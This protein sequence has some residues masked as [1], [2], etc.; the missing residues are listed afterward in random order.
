[1]HVAPTSRSKVGTKVSLS[2]CPPLLSPAPKV[3]LNCVELWQC[4]KGLW[5]HG[6]VKNPCQ[7]Y[8][9]GYT[10][11]PW[12]DINALVCYVNC[13]WVWVDMSRKWKVSCG[14]IMVHG[15]VKSSCRSWSDIVRDDDPHPNCALLLHKTQVGN[16][17]TQLVE[18]SNGSQCWISFRNK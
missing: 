13:V 5:L 1:M 18:N 4:A 16:P 8:E 3:S 2:R 6:T 14:S 11:A 17:T 15:Y 7:N 10:P 9:C 12:L